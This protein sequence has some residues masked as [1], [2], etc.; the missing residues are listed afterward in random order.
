[1]INIYYRGLGGRYTNYL[2]ETAKKVSR[3]RVMQVTNR[4]PVRSGYKIAVC[5]NGVALTR[6]K[7]AGYLANK[8][9]TFIVGDSNGLPESIANQCEERVTV[10]S[11]AGHHTLEAAL[12][13][14]E[15]ERIIFQT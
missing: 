2:Q 13:T 12:L 6:E 14:E 7:L 10:S 15:I 9:I 3:R 8:E 4:M 1:M 5:Q 11:L